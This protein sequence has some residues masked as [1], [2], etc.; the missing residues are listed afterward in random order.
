MKYALFLTERE[1]CHF[2]FTDEEE[3]LRTAVQLQATSV[4]IQ[5]TKQV[6]RM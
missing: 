2:L 5:K 1:Q 6:L 4:E 3:G